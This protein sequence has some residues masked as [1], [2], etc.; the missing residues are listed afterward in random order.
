MFTI[1]W[2]LM[3]NPLPLPHWHTQIQH[4][5]RRFL[6]LILSSFLLKSSL[7]LQWLS[8]FIFHCSCSSWSHTSMKIFFLHRNGWEFMLISK[9]LYLYLTLTHSKWEMSFKSRDLY[10]ENFTIWVNEGWEIIFYYAHGWQCGCDWSAIN[11]I[12]GCFQ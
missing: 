1:Y 3:W 4:R 12:L 8:S 9:G 7:Q 2:L 11:Q 10:M 5:P 6:F